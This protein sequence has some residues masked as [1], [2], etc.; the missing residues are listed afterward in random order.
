MRRGHGFHQAFA[1]KSVH[2]SGQRFL[3][4]GLRIGRH[5]R[6]IFRR[7]FGLHVPGSC[8]GHGQTA[9]QQAVRIVKGGSQDLSAG[10]IL[11]GGGDAPLHPHAGSIHGLGNTETGQGRAIGAQ[12]EDGFHG[13]ALGLLEGSAASSGLYREPSA[14]MRSTASLS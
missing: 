1:P 14:M 5:H 11:P 9:I 7:P 8:P 12:Q 2:G 10:Q 4:Q 3:Q 6:Q 13:V